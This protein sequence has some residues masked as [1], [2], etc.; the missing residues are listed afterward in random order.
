MGSAMLT[1]RKPESES[2]EERSVAV[3]TL[4]LTWAATVGGVIKRSTSLP[5]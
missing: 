3:Q 5:I 2:T 4:Q 1:P